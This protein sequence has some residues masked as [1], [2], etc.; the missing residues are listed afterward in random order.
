M[1]DKE[2]SAAQKANDGGMTHDEQA[3]AEQA[4]PQMSE[5][6]RRQ[7]RVLMFIVVGLGV[8]L[9]AGL[10]VLVTTVIMRASARAPGV[11]GVEMAVS[12]PRGAVVEEMKL[13]GGTLA[14]RLR[15]K[16]GARQIIVLDARRGRL[17]R[18]VRLTEGGSE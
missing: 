6:D 11:A 15:G 14:L 18:R 2:H 3:A 12:V 8:L 5:A 10:A 4:A 16:D 13:D 9:V 7:V 1:A 17:L